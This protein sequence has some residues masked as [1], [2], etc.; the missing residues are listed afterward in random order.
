VLHNIFGDSIGLKLHHFFVDNQKKHTKPNTILRILRHDSIDLFPNQS[1]SF[2][3]ARAQ[4]PKSLTEILH[5]HKHV[6]LTSSK[7]MLQP[8]QVVKPQSTGPSGRENP[9]VGREKCH[10]AV[11]ATLSLPLSLPAFPKLARTHVQ[12]MSSA[13]ARSTLWNCHN[14]RGKQQI[15]NIDLAAAGQIFSVTLF[16][17]EKVFRPAHVPSKLCRLPTSTQNML[18]QRTKM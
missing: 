1:P 11:F 16:P 14:P 15:K 9:F 18:G 10:N 6:S 17:A 13:E 8:F 3:C 7:I 12:L 2:I 4:H 5:S